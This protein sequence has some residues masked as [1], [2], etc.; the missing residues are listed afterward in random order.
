MHTQRRTTRSKPALRARRAENSCSLRSK[1][2]YS[3]PIRQLVGQHGRNYYSTPGCPP[4]KV[5]HSYHLRETARLMPQTTKEKALAR[6]KALLAA[7]QSFLECVA[8]SRRK[9]ALIYSHNAGECYK[10]AGDGGWNVSD[11]GCAAKAYACAREYGRA[12]ELYWKCD[13]FDEAIDI[14]RNHRRAIDP[15][16]AEGLLEA[17]RYFYLKRKEYK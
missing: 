11:Y 12:V 17:A 6:R 3:T 1:T 2:L 9:E 5:A 4:C 8:A 15:K 7:A 16:V 10:L 13:M 14:L